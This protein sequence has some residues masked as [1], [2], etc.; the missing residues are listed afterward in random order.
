[1]QNFLTRKTGFYLNQSQLDLSDSNNG[2][3]SNLTVAYVP[4]VDGGLLFVPVTISS[5]KQ[6][7]SLVVD[8]SIL[9]LNFSVTYVCYDRN[10]S[11]GIG[12]LI[13]YPWI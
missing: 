9:S 4:V 8:I 3:Q 2:T 11:Q 12:L 10:T 13:K 5:E 1:M 7:S 6:T